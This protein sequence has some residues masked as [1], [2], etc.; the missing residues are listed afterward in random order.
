MKYRN[1]MNVLLT[2]LLL[3]ALPAFSQAVLVTWNTTAP[4][5]GY[6]AYNEPDGPYEGVNSRTSYYTGLPRSDYRYRW[7]GQSY[8][9][10]SESYELTAVT[11]L[12]A[13]ISTHTQ[14]KEFTI[15]I[16]E[17]SGLGTTDS[18]GNGV[19]LSSQSGV[20]P[21]E[22]LESDYYMTFILDSSIILDANTTYAVIFGVDEP[23]SANT[24]VNHV[25]LRT[26]GNSTSNEDWRAWEYRAEHP[27]N[28]SVWRTAITDNPDGSGVNNRNQPIVYLHGTLV[29]E[30]GTYAL[31]FLGSLALF[32]VIKRSRKSHP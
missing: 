4:D 6:F 19:L 2:T 28:G 31:L 20:L 26:S 27:V 22:V 10:G 16:Y 13:G 24:S 8:T 15:R 32:G 17:T 29:P 25:V 1:P 9:M 14:G 18:P 23:T 21:N 7:A 30:P 3:S 5:S 12:I 11:W